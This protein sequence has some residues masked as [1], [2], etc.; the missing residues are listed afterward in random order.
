M[1]KIML[2]ISLCSCLGLAAMDLFDPS[3][4]ERTGI[5]DIHK[6]DS[7]VKVFGALV[8]LSRDEKYLPCSMAWLLPRVALKDKNLNVVKALGSV[9]PQDLAQA[10]ATHFLDPNGSA[11]TY[12]GQSLQGGKVTVPAYMN[13]RVSDNEQSANL[14][15]IFLY[16]FNGAT[17]FLKTLKPL[18]YG[19][20]GKSVGDHEVDFERYTSEL[21]YNKD[22][23]EWEVARGFFSHHGGG[24]LVKANDIQFEGTHPI[25]FA[26]EFGHA[27]YNKPFCLNL[28]GDTVTANGSRWE[29]WNN[30]EILDRDNPSSQQV[31]I[32][33]A[34]RLGVDVT[35]NPLSKGTQLA[36]TGL[37]ARGWFK[38]V[39]ESNL[40]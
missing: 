36:P 30:Y 17:P 25:V 5:D 40:K 24:D 38:N 1:K 3:K 39:D 2:M 10:D 9:T 11:L 29:T 19:V 23:E 6:V 14:Q 22:T 26:A 27:S 34:G 7:V 18:V 32:N 33:Y 37:A 16:S 35:Q 31:W 28:K 4:S 8:K 20:L 15:S 21:Q 12:A 13:Y